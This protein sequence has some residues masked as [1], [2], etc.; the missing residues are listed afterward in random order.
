MVS[1]DP[2]LSV[3]SC[4]FSSTVLLLAL[5]LT[6][7]SYLNNRQ[8]QWIPR[9]ESGYKHE[10]G[11]IPAT[12]YE[13]IIN[14]QDSVVRRT[15]PPESLD[16]HGAFWNVTQGLA[17]CTS[18]RLGMSRSAGFNRATDD[19]ATQYCNISDICICI[20]PCTVMVHQWL[21]ASP[22]FNSV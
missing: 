22:V 3:S 8:Q 9:G 17:D 19:L 5:A 7:I 20:V 14:A 16:K 12:L 11:F 13:W 15:V 4:A 1:T 21:S 18:A 10:H 6:S 2:P